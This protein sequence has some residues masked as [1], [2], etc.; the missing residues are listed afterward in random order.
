MGFGLGSGGHLRR[1][2]FFFWGGSGDRGD[3]M[4]PNIRSARNACLRATHGRAEEA[5][6]GNE[7]AVQN[8]GFRA[9]YRPGPS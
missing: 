7:P 3:V 2:G 9:A 4:A 1:L 6:P 5:G 8:I